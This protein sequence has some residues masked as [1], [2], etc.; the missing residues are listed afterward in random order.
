MAPSL[1]IIIPCFNS[2]RT[3]SEAVASCYT[4]DLALTDFE[5]ILVDDGSSDTTK[6]LIEELAGS[7]PNIKSLFHSENRGGGAARNTGIKA[8]QGEVLF[9]LDSDNFFAPNSVRPILHY[10]NERQLDGVA[11]FER[12][13]FTGNNHATYDTHTNTKYDSDIEIGDLFSIKNHILLDNFFYTRTAYNKT[14]GYPE[15]HGFDTQCYELRFLAAGNR[16]Q[17]VPGSIFFHRQDTGQ[18]SYF[19]RVYKQGYFSRNIYLI[20]EDL[21]HLF[22]VNVRRLIMEFD[23]FQNTKLDTHNL[24]AKLDQQLEAYP[25]DFL[26]PN[27]RS[28]L[29]PSGRHERKTILE[30]SSAPEDIFAVAVMSYHDGHLEAAA[31]AYTTLLQKGIDSVVIYFNLL[32]LHVASTKK[33]PPR[34]IDDEVQ[35]LVLRLCPKQQ[36]L[37]RLAAILHRVALMIRSVW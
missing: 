12:R 2:A 37:G 31:T 16:V 10:L 8:S 36:T 3:L 21:I 27:Y 17:V 4:Q 19:Q 7:H 14:A 35:R 11:Y 20:S 33:Y 22:S 18:N 5:I 13:Y 23:I 26:I 1:S 30:A 32:R 15:H 6:A 25:N 34:S 28:Y 24:K 29:T 9:C